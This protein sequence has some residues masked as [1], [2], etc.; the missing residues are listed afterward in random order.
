MGI[1]RKVTV[2]DFKKLNL[3]GIKSD[4]GE[5]TRPSRHEMEFQRTN[6]WNRTGISTI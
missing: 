6:N 2:H 1:V 3:Q 5:G 4:Y